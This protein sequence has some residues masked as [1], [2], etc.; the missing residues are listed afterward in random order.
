MSKAITQQEFELRIKEH[1]PDEHFKILQYTTMSNPCAIECLNCHQ[2]IHYPQA[3]NFLVK[4]KKAGCSACNGLKAKNTINLKRLQEKYTIL[5]Q[6]RRKNAL[7]YTCQCKM[8]GRI[9]THQ[10][11]SFLTTTCRCEGNGNRWTEEELKSKLLEE[12]GEEYILLSPFQTVN[13]K[14]LFKHSCGFIWSTTPGHLLYNKTQCPKCCRKQSKG[15][16]LIAAQLTELQIPYETEKFLHNSLQRF[17]FFFYFNDQAYAIEYN[18]EQHYRYNPFFHGSQIETFYKYQERDA[19]K[20]QY[21][22]ENHIQLIIIPYTYS[23][24]EIK[25]CI[26]KLFSSPT[27]SSV[28]VASSEA[29]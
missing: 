1:F 8:C 25:D 20:K 28:N 23:N 16:K 7:W 4:N 26:N 6:E 19:R 17:D 2:I 21:C 11:Y 14:A 22:E 18:G 3:K 13:D 5:S 24:T 12:F 15:C 27:T 9:S 10:L 29:K